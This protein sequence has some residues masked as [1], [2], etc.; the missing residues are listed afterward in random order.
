[1][2]EQPKK[3]SKSTGVLSERTKFVAMELFKA[4][5]VDVNLRRR[6]TAKKIEDSFTEAA[7]YVEMEKAYDSGQPIKKPMEQV[8][9]P[10]VTVVEWNHQ[11]GGPQNDEYGKPVVVERQA[12]VYSYA[13]GKPADYPTNTAYIKGRLQLGMPIRKDLKE[14]AERYFRELKDSGIEA[15]LVLV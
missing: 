6:T 5:S 13:P 15:K 9:A 11:Q 8:I 12:D 7:L 2:A 3:E 14:P 1:M 10:T 4:K